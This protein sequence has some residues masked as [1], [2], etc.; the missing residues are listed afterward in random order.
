MKVNSELD[1]YKTWFYQKVGINI[2]NA[3]IKCGDSQDGLSNA[4]G[5]SRVSMVNIE[6]GKQRLPAHLINDIAHFLGIDINI[7]I[8][9]KYDYLKQMQDKP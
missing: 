7:L 6:N 5:I 9:S 3:R 1:N 4:L 8:P 2:K